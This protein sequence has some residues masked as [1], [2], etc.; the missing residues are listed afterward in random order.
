[1]E[2]SPRKSNF[3]LNYIYLSKRLFSIKKENAE[4][5]MK[6]T[7]EVRQESITFPGIPQ[8]AACLY[9]SDSVMCFF[10][11]NQGSVSSQL[12]SRNAAAVIEVDFGIFISLWIF[13]PNSPKWVLKCKGWIKKNIPMNDR[14]TVCL[15]VL[16][17]KM[18]F[19]RQNVSQRQNSSLNVHSE[20][21]RQPSMDIPSPYLCPVSKNLSSILIYVS[22]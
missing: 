5:A 11:E 22:S 7:E 8:L 3:Y 16:I 17:Y 21:N 10:I 20:Q 2:R 18:G 14:S 4:E 13:V 15:S 12:L 1:M 6:Q 9:H 19:K